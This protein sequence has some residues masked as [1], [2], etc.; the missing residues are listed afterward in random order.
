MKNT[1]IDIWNNI[2]NI[3]SIILDK[4]V[5]KIKEPLY[6]TIFFTSLHFC[7]KSLIYGKIF[8]TFTNLFIALL[9]LNLWSGKKGN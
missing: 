6:I 9:F 5:E 7:I 3:F 2:S 4:I 1:L 8:E